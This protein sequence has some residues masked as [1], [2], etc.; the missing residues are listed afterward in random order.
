MTEITN[1]IDLSQLT[2]DEL[3]AL[4]EAV[5]QEFE[6]RNTTLEDVEPEPAVD[7]QVGRSVEQDDEEN[8]N[9]YGFEEWEERRTVGQSEIDAAHEEYVADIDCEDE[10]R[11]IWRA[12]KDANRDDIAV[13]ARNRLD[14]L[15]SEDEED[16]E[17]DDEESGD[18][19]LPDADEN[20][21]ETTDEDENYTFEVETG[22]LRKEVA[23]SLPDDMDYDLDGSPTQV[24]GI[25]DSRAGTADTLAE[26]IYQHRGDLMNGQVDN[27]MSFFVSQGFSDYIDID[28]EW[29]DN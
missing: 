18:I 2:E 1:V 4:S 27:R 22:R 28:K 21:A 8:Q 11:D 10:A 23:I 17:A 29:A 6:T 5:E 19:N 16:V 3:E 26:W 15:L 24:P 13:A 14:E 9:E 12:A 25:G 7:V 20:E